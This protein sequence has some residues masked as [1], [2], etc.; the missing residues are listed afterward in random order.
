MVYEWIKWLLNNLKIQ[1]QIL[2]KE[3]HIKAPRDMALCTKM[4]HDL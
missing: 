4:R 3:Y 2:V 1:V